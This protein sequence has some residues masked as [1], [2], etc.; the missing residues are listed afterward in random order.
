MLQTQAT[1]SPETFGVCSP[2]HKGSGPSISGELIRGN[3][4][5]AAAMALEAEDLYNKRLAN[6]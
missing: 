5:A 4:H 1:V 2:T 3:I 6:G